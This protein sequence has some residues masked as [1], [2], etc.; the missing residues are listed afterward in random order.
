MVDDTKGAIDPAPFWDDDGKGWMVHGFAK[1]RA[2]FANRIV[3]K[4]L[5]ED[6]THT[7]GKGTVIID[8]D[9]MPKVETSLGGRPW[10][11]TEGPK[12]YK[13]NG[14]YYIFVPSG[15]VKGGWQGVFRS[16]SIEGPYEGRDVLDQGRTAVNGPHQGA[17]V[18]TPKG[19]DWFLHFQDRDTYGRVVLLEPMRWVK[20]WPIIGKPVGSTGRGEP[21]EIYKKPNLP[22]QPITA[23]ASSDDFKGSLSLAWSFASNPSPDWAKVSGGA[24]HLLAVP[25]PADLFENGA[26][27]S[28]RLPGL[29]FAATTRLTFKPRSSGETAG[30]AIHGRT[31]AWVGLE[32]T[33]A[34]V[35][36]VSYTKHSI[37]PGDTISRSPGPLLPEG[38]V[39]LRLTAKPALIEVPPPGFS[40]Y[41]PSML[42]EEQA[43]ASLAYSLNGKTYTD[44]G[45]PFLVQPGFWVGAR[46]GLFASAPYGTPAAIATTNGVADFDFFRTAGQ[47]QPQEPAGGRH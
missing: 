45:E 5:S 41:W 25:G 33:P 40:P 4:A 2:G 20:D 23:P 28:Q 1:S 34:G 43:M 13:R 12:L 10:Q 8:A 7:T 46:I 32:N 27:L 6:D 39:W 29:S 9:A 30:L 38:R 36:V 47:N 35:Q 11:T 3:L 31:F 42:R 26:I 14:W 22:S 21:V 16:R 15:S 37:K 19:E 24:L 18:S 44:L 17:W